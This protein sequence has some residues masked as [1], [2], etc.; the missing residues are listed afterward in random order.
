MPSDPTVSREV[1]FRSRRF[2]SPLVGIIR[3]VHEFLA[4]PDD[5]RMF[6]FG[7]ELS[8]A[9]G[10]LGHQVPPRTGGAHYLRERA[11]A[12][13]LGEALERYCGTH[14]PAA[15]L[16]F[17]SAA[18]LG[19][20]AVSPSD[21][22]LFH[23]RQ[24]SQAGFPYRPFTPETRVQ[25]V[26]GISLTDGAPVFLPAQLVFLAPGRRQGEPAIGYATS[27]GMAC[28]PTPDEAVLRA[29]LEAV[30]RD[31][32]M[33][34][35]YGRLALPLVDLE[36]DPLLC[37]EVR[38][39]F[40]PARL[41]HQV[42]DLSVFL[43]VPTALAV[44]R[45]RSPDAIGLAVGAA[46]APTMREACGKALRE[47][48]QTR[49]WIRQM[50]QLRR[51][52]FAPDFSDIL[53]FEDHVLLYSYEENAR[54]ADFLIASE[55]LRSLQQIPPLEGTTASERISAVVARLAQHGVRA[56]AA[57]LTSP[58]VR[59]AGLHVTRV[60]CPQLCPLDVGYQRRFLGGPRLYEAA[61]RLGLRERP[62][63]FEELNPYPHP[64]P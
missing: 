6:F 12:A 22:A 40:T 24:Y 48:F 50:R 14:A 60:L 10:I 57:D 53:R 21:F 34:T 33:L 42:V 18:E 37:A 59:Q 3:H 19:P 31:A 1:A 61:W 51:R 38:R 2:V 46:S 9:T 5:A 23:P 11:L 39:H 8:E 56:Y 55:Q 4:A 36:S 44:I 20:Q 17:A 58:E 25:W 41:R 32:F 35:W 30:E 45:G 64:F 7:C 29:L 54:R 49:H 63:E 13:A 52:A 28:G 47:A 26:P 27:S 62:L 43:R 16:V 15:H